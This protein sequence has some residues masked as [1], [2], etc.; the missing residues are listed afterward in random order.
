MAPRLRDPTARPSPADIAFTRRAMQEL[1]AIRASTPLLRLQDADDVQRRL[2]FH[3]TGPASDPQLIVGELD[4][5]GLA[6]AGFGGLIYL[7]NAA[8]QVRTLIVPG[9][10]GTAWRLHPAQRSAAGA[11]FDTASGRFTVPPRSAVVYVRR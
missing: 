6:G 11:R 3:G 8:D 4:G 1:L 9:A 2:R 7:L 5:A 10:A